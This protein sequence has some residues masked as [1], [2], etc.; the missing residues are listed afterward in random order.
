MLNVI[1]VGVSGPSASGKTSI[2][3]AIMNEL[4]SNQIE[5]ISEDSYYKCNKH[6]PKKK[7]LHVNYDH[8]NSLDHELLYN[9]LQKLKNG[10]SYY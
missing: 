4:G 7:R 8:P 6:I 10:F 1:I 3:N 2:S 5:V 9:Q